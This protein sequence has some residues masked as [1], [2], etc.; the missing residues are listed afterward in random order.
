[1]EGAERGE[2]GGW[3]VTARLKWERTEGKVSPGI[4]NELAGGCMSAVHRAQVADHGESTGCST[5]LAERAAALG[6]GGRSR[7]LVI[8]R[9]WGSRA[10]R[11]S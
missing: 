7:V 10:L 5:G 4:V 6:W 2:R 9:T 8:M 1:M 11:G 3:S